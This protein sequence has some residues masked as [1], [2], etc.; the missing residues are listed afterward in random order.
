[1]ELSGNAV[2]NNIN[3]DIRAGLCFEIANIVISAKNKNKTK[4]NENRLG[5]TL[6]LSQMTALLSFV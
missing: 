3:R 1:M 5:T 6:V 4:D 2:T